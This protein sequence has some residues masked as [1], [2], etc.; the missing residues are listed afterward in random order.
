M[1]I[2]YA[3]FSLAVVDF[4]ALL[5]RNEN[6]YFQPVTVGKHSQIALSKLKGNEKIMFQYNIPF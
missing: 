4:T 2:Q 5:D 1:Q 6:S 3:S